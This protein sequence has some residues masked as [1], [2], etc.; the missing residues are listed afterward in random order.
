MADYVLNHFAEL[1]VDLNRIV[2]MNA[3]NHVRAPTD[4]DL[5]FIAPLTVVAIIA[6]GALTGALGSA[7]S[8]RRYMTV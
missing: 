7:L 3:R 8:L 2:S 6:G 1:A 5:V 4:V